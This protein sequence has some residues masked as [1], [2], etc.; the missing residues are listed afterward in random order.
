MFQNLYFS[1]FSCVNSAVVQHGSISLF[2]SVNV[3]QCH[4]A[5]SMFTL[6]QPASKPSSSHFLVSAYLAFCCTCCCLI[7]F[8]ALYHERWHIIWKHPYVL[9]LRCCENICL[10]LRTWLLKEKKN[11]ALIEKSCTRMLSIR[12]KPSVGFLSYF[13]GVLTV[14][15]SINLSFSF[16]LSIWCLTCTITCTLVVIFAALCCGLN[17]AW[18]T[19][20]FHGFQICVW[21]RPPNFYSLVDTLTYS[22]EYKMIYGSFTQEV[23]NTHLKS[24][25]FNNTEPNYVSK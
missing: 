22:C 9:S 17:D 6:H 1:L 12:R 25:C 24:W 14:I 10:Y 3:Q 18:F 20:R 2:T 7:W 5:F 13:G 8:S 15:W 11:H 23:A 19:I 21:T 16:S 4:I